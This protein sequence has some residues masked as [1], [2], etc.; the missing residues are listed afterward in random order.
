MAIQ[1]HSTHVLPILTALLFVFLQ[2][3]VMDISN[4]EKTVMMGTISM[5]T[6]VQVIVNLIHSQ[7]SVA[8]KMDRQSMILIIMGTH[9]QQP[10]LDCVMS[11][12]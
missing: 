6:A 1:T 7:V 4:P 8:H 5:E 3:V 10:A 2:V 9:L 11:E 12:R